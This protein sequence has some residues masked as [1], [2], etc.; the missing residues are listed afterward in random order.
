MGAVHSNDTKKTRTRV[1]RKRFWLYAAVAGIVSAAA[2][3]AVAEVIALVVARDGSPVLAVGA[4]VIDIVPRWAKEFAIE[5]FGANDK[6]FLLGSIGLAVV[7][8]AALAGVLQLAKRP[9]GLV[10]FGLAGVLAIAAIVTRT[11]ATPFASVPTI[12]GAAAGIVLLHLLVRRLARWRDDVR[13]EAAATTAPD[14]R[15]HARPAADAAPAPRAVGVDRRR[16]LVGTLVVAA[17]SAV[18]GTGARLVSAATS[19][20]AGIRDSLS[21]PT[22]KSTVDVPAGAELDIDGITPLYT[23]NADFYRVDTALTVP[24]VDPATWSLKITGMVDEEVTLSF[25]DLVNMGLDEYS[26]TMT[27]VSNEVGGGLVG[28][29]KWLGVPIRDVLA[30][31]GPQSGADMVLSKSVDGYTASTPLEAVTDDNREAI[32]AVAMN[33]EPLPFEHGF[34]VRMVVPGLYGYVSATKWV[35]EI[36]VTTFEA[37]EAYWTPRG[38]DAEAPIKMSSRIDTPRVDK[39]IGAGPAK[40]AG[41][42]W[43]QTVGIERVEV[44]IDNGDWQAATLSTPINADTWVQWFV[45]WTATTGTHYVAVRAVDKAGNTQLEER[46]PIAPNGSAGWQ[47]TLVTVV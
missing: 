12:I 38:Y 1:P 7:V 35:T 15:D 17:A 34:P 9:L 23:S 36:K 10:L 8:A 44:S 25:Q 24:Q 31:A 47:R 20:L 30:M 45:D 39:Q 6:I 11:G 40:I 33:G 46:A 16:F 26:I 28:T 27:C 22:A 2:L 4:F 18:V 13:A 43:A 3:L 14:A 19:S 42:A 37:D 5:T 41:V 21:L 29:A 32:F